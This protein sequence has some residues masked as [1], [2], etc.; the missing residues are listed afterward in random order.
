MSPMLRAL[1]ND[2]C[3]RD[4]NVSYPINK[5]GMTMEENVQ[6]VASL[7]LEDKEKQFEV[8]LRR[9]F[10]LFQG[11]VSEIN[12]ARNNADSLLA[13]NINIRGQNDELAKRVIEM[14]Q[15]IKKRSGQSDTM[16]KKVIEYLNNDEKSL[17]ERERNQ[18]ALDRFW[19]YRNKQGYRDRLYELYISYLY[20]RNGWSV[21]YRGKLK[22]YADLGRDIVCKK[23]N[24]S[25][26]VQCKNY[27]VNS[28][29]VVQEKHICQLIGTRDV[30][31]RDL[32]SLCKVYG[33]FYASTSF[34]IPAREVANR[35][36]IILRDS[37]PLQQY[38]SIKCINIDGERI[39][40]LPFEEDYIKFSVV[41]GNG[42]F[43]CSTVAEAEAAG[44]HYAHPDRYAPKGD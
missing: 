23:G 40:C 5:A 22:G 26:I 39:Y 3:K 38:P 7:S 20:E 14:E 12:L 44:F 31:L 9:I 21:E 33:V 30:Y 25:Y 36:N 1:W 19:G 43:Y 2:T 8:L 17:S 13:E 35:F 16:K 34:S 37:I 41:R 11:L 4:D 29:N 10:N 27:S 42:D 15:R 6:D 24:T 28:H 18:K 32:S